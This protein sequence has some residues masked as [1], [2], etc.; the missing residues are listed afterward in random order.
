MSVQEEGFKV[1]W[2]FL[3]EER[4]RQ[5]K[6]VEKKGGGR[7]ASKPVLASSLEYYL[8]HTAWKSE[9]GT[10]VK[11]EVN[12]D[13]ISTSLCFSFYTFLPYISASPATT[14]ITSCK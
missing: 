2:G 14:T 4:V 9:W 13:E 10:C 7:G 11:V 6:V 12:K 5:G 1:G 3:R 8:L